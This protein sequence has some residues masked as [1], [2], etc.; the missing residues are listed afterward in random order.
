MRVVEDLE[1]SIAALEIV[2][3]GSPHGLLRRWTGWD[4]RRG[5]R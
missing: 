1:T 5:R 2:D 3:V 4:E